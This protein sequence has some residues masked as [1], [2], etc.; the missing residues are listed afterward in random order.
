M[1]TERKSEFVAT[2]ATIKDVARIAEVSVVTVSRVFNN[3]PNVSEEMRRRVLKA[4]GD[5]GYVGS[6]NYVSELRYSQERAESRSDLKQIGFFFHLDGDSPSSIPFWS[7]IMLGVESEASKAN[8]NVLF[9]SISDLV[10][11]PEALLQ[12]VQQMD[13]GGI[14]LSGPP[15]LEVI[16]LVRRVHLPLVLVDTDLPNQPV[17]AVLSDYFGGSLEAVSYLIQ[18]GHTRIA[19]LSSPA[20][21]KIYTVELR[22]MGYRSALLKA[23]LPIDEDLYALSNPR[24]STIHSSLS[25]D[26]GYEACKR[27]LERQIS[28]SALFCVNDLMAAGA[29]RA[30][31]EAGRRVPE[32]VSLIGFDDM[33]MAEHLVPALTT[34]RVNREAMGR[35]AMKTLI[36]QA[37]HP[38]DVYVTTVLKVE[39]MKRASVLP[40]QE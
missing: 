30:L 7:S 16:N 27:L 20:M 13:I 36:E 21:D 28:F 17:N 32:D 34:V 4:A 22:L 33:E 6:K 26:G 29:L 38:N 5:V 9:R 2:S 39:L 12:M 3:H 14:L 25:A 11:S 24:T 31:R 8:I 23:G 37:E 19:F 40:F 15:D 1:N 35:I 10:Q 18:Q